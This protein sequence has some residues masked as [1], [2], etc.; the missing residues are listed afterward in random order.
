MASPQRR[1]PARYTV[2][3]YMALE[4]TA[5]HRHEFYQGEVWAMAGATALHNELCYSCTA[6]LKGAARKQG[7]KVFSENV[8]LAV[9]DGRFYT[10]PDV[11]ATCHDEDVLAERTMRNPV[12]LIEVLSPSTADYDRVWKRFRYQQLPSLRHYLLVSQQYQ[13]VD[14]Y[15]RASDTADWQHQVLTMPDEA[16]EIPELA[17][18]L[19]LADIYADLGVP[20][21]TDD[22][23]GMEKQN[24]RPE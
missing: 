22:N 2:E 10:Y 17:T 3:E 23:A 5:E 16:A 12:L 9:A 14:W 1:L 7:C 24:D 18:R 11:M 19:L 21:V 8:Q 4:E 15:H 6:A 13:A 20:L